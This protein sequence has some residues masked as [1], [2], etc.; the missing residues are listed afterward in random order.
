MAKLF[1]ICEVCK[2]KKLFIDYRTYVLANKEIATSQKQMCNT[3][4]AGVNKLITPK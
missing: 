4:Y 3:C 1:S 2:K